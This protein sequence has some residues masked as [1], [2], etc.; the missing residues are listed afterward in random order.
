[1]R[2]LR[3]R[4]LQGL[5]DLPEVRINGDMTH[6]IANNLNITLT[7]ENCDALLASLTDIAVSSTSACS[8]GSAMPSHVL[9]A[10][11]ADRAAAG[12]SIRITV[13]RFNTEEEIDYAV[14]YLRQKIEDCRAG[15][16]RAA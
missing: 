7:L 10:L 6:R 2:A 15:R 1:M 5:S 12:N 9:Q 8:A 16:L 13:G 14:S 11:G 4:L 3:D